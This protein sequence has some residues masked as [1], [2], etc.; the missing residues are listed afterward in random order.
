ME[1]TFRVAFRFK[2]L[3]EIIVPTTAK[4]LQNSLHL[5]VGTD[6]NRPRPFK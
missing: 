4:E 2:V 3:W 1:Q 5:V 6:A